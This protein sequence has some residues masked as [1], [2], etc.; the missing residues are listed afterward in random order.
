[1][2]LDRQV[3]GIIILGRRCCIIQV[4]RDVITAGVAVRG[5]ALQHVGLVDIPR[6]VY[7]FVAHNIGV[8]VLG[9]VVGWN[10]P[11]GRRASWRHLI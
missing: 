10:T 6:N 2:L 4:F 5:A 9:L 7:V 8:I 11:L 1:M 3:L